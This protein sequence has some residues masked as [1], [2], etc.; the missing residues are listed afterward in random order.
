VIGYLNQRRSNRSARQIGPNRW[1]HPNNRSSL[2]GV[3]ASNVSFATVALITSVARPR[4][5][6]S[7]SGSAG[8]GSI[9]WQRGR[10]YTVLDVHLYREVGHWD[11]RHVAQE[12]E[13][14]AKRGRSASTGR[15]VKQST[16]KRHPN[17]TVNESTGKNTKKK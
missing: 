7:L 12:G 9:A 11:G 15:F 13:Q 8:P 16:V 17:T 5:G 10:P 3:G 4:P 1:T 6:E 2:L 14:M